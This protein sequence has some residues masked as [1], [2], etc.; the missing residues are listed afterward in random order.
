MGNCHE[1]YVGVVTQKGTGSRRARVQ[2]PRGEA[3]RSWWSEL[4]EPEPSYR[5]RPTATRR[6]L[7]DSLTR[8][9]SADMPATSIARDSESYW[10]RHS[11]APS[12]SRPTPSERDDL[13]GVNANIGVQPV[14]QSCAARRSRLEPMRKVTAMIKRH[15]TN[16][17]TYFTHRLYPAGAWSGT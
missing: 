8:S 4:S 7:H 9:A 17:R 15:W 13:Q 2:L 12:R 11:A 14:V 5:V 3:R 10:T 16:I 1:E 6:R